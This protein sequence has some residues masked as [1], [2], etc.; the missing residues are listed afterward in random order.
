MLLGRAVWDPALRRSAPVLRDW[1]DLLSLL[2]AVAALCL[3]AASGWTPLYGPLT[4]LQVASAV[5]ALGLVCL[6]VIEVGRGSCARDVRE[7]AGP[8]CGALLA[9]YLALLGSASLRTFVEAG[10]HLKELS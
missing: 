4:V 7:L 9:A 8:A 5:V 6:T 2:G 1:W 3:V 10:L